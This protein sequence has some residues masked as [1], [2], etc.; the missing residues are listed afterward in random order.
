MSTDF[1]HLH[2][3]SG[4]SMRYG[5]AMPGALVDR[6]VQHGQA[7]LALTD[8]DGLYG[9]VRFVEA[10]EKAGIR[11]V[12]GVDLAM[13]ASPPPCDGSGRSGGP[14]RAE[15]RV[16]RS[17][18]RGGTVVDPRLPRVTVLARGSAPWVGDR[19][20]R[21]A[22][23]GGAG[24]VGA[25]GAAGLGGPGGRTPD[26]SM[27]GVFPVGRVAHRAGWAALC[28]LVTDTHLAGERGTPVCTPEILA[29]WAEPGATSRPAT[30][31]AATAGAAM[32]SGTMDGGAIGGAATDGAL[33][34]QSG[35][36]RPSR[37]DA[38][39]LVVLLGPDSD[40]GRALLAKQR[41]RARDLLLAWQ[42]LLPPGSVVVEVVCHG[43]PDGTPASRSHARRLL[44][45]A[46][47]TGTPAVLTA[48]ARHLDPGDSRTVDVLDAARRL[49]ALDPRH[50]DR[51][52][53]A[54]HLASTAAMRAV[55]REV[56]G[57]D[58]ER[59]RRLIETTGALAD[60][61]VQ[62]RR[63]DLGIGM[64]HLP[65]PHVLGIPDDV[66]PLAVLEERTRAA[67]ARCYPGASDAHLH[68][69]HTRLTEELKVIAGHG[70]PMYF[71]T[72]A[73][74]VDL[75][76]AQD[77][78]VAARGSGVGSLVNHLLGVSGIDP[79]RHGLLMERFCSSMRKELPDIDIDVESARRTE[80][81]ERVLE[82]FGGDRVTCVSMMDTYK[83]RHAIRD[84]GA[85][86]G[87]PPVEV[88]EIAKAFPHISARNARNAI[89]ELPELRMRG[90][91]APR[92]RTFFDLVERLDGLP[93]HIALHPCG[94]VLSGGGLLDRT[95][96]EAS[97][98]GFP[99]SQFDKDDVETL[100]LLK[101]DVLGIRMQSAMAHA[102]AEVE[103]VDGVHLDLDDE[104]QVPR[105]DPA[106]YAMIR[107]THTLGCFQIESP[108][109]RELVGKL[110]PERFD[111]LIADISLFR[112]GP[113]K[114]D[115]ITPFLESR[116]RWRRRELL[117]PSLASALAET[118]GVVVYHE[119][120]LR[121][122]AE[123]TG[124]SLAKA[125][126]VRRGMGS[127]AG[128]EEIEAWW[129]PRAKARGYS[130]EDRDR[131]WAVLKSFASFGF[132]KAH[133]ASFA[134]P[135]FHSAWLKAHHPAAFLAGVL[136]H[137]PGMYPKRLILDDART[138]GIAVLPLDV[139][140]SDGTYRVERIPV[141]QEHV[142]L[143]PDLPDGS[144]Y[145]IRLS[146]AD[147]RGMSEA[148]VERIVAGQPYADLAD[149]WGRARVS[150]PVVERLVVA[151]GFDGIYGTGSTRTGMGR[152]GRVTRRDV[153]LHVA[154]L[155]RYDRALAGG[156]RSTPR[157]RAAPTG[158]DPRIRAAAQSR[159]AAPVVAASDQPTQLTLDLGDAPALRAGAGLPEMTGAER[160][161]AEL[162][163]LGL[164]ASAHVVEF[165][166]PML[167]ALRVTRSRDL[168][169]A[170]SGSSILV[171]GVKVATQTPP[172]RSGRR[173][174]FLTLDDGTGPADAT[175]FED[176]QGP[177]AGTVFH[178]WLLL[179]RGIVR[180][181]GERGISLRAT[182]A[183]ELGSLWEAWEH[184]G[185]AAVRAALEQADA[186]A[187]ALATAG[188]EAAADALARGH[189]VLVH[190]SGFK[191]S[192]YAD[193]RPPGLDPKDGRG[194][195]RPDLVP[196][197]GARSAPESPGS[198][199]GV[200]GSAPEVPGSAPEVPGSG[201]GVLGSGPGGEDF[202]PPASGDLDL[203]PRRRI[204]APGDDLSVPPSKLWHSS[205]GS[206]GH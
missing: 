158:D 20:A 72:V 10:T 144:A 61:C 3:A 14:G 75:I 109:Q 178:S 162:E 153:L 126:E 189:R 66:D 76:R 24:V 41:D 50:L 88:D 57:E 163:V 63:R 12:L 105:D 113:V 117:H 99:M 49:V 62:R 119:Q 48:M 175:F 53:E 80:I 91:D 142:P 177:Y 37:G 22:A 43:G 84:V 95:P 174:V 171:A 106:T 196:E 140:L 116:H 68:T 58:T 173:V 5:T 181:T 130:P 169:G 139:N 146:L 121:I 74:V 192:P 197:V 28:R 82:R 93:R 137:D 201:P 129:R 89:V 86:L 159:G 157:R 31:T 112:P 115:M 13:G 166:E 71:L 59:A 205:Q 133:A 193:T 103:R 131:I 108:G 16:R 54:G 9:A 19:G 120:V 101:L 11:A 191:Q 135:T 44:G 143:H 6:A 187:R 55:A 111:D 202:D 118:E 18:A 39:P 125:D 42:T 200:P 185:V 122:V 206:S 100:G 155:D 176:V 148:E 7:T 35:D 180:R 123:T 154:E 15:P 179:V 30:A 85:A 23:L 149:F 97:W 172:I 83:V 47:E 104:T 60:A 186:Q 127:P 168:L 73:A 134:L 96:V 51:T 33:G 147:V 167:R 136:T 8:R 145:G 188:E 4:F 198:G 102:V 160:V 194:A 32:G 46:D 17:P 199:S 56:A 182:G 2:V 77:V 94:I 79:L 36:H 70:Y 45:L 170:R 152:R 204:G 124:C 27:G 65:E 161:R 34:G 195:P 151:G 98:L 25:G 183:W 87:M 67:V 52:T 81:Y 29:R 64:S 132:C 38:S 110:G 164:D 138:L 141:W 156:R 92:L 40:V 90:L 114:S 1:A 107:T 150:R 21:R 26:A 165:Y 184:G 128:Q 78:R 190:A 69:V 203:P